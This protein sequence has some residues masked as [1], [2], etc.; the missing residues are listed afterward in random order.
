MSDMEDTKKP[1][2]VRSTKK[3]GGKK[4]KNPYIIFCNMK[5]EEVKAANPDLP[6]KEILSKLVEM[7][8]GLTEEQKASYRP[9]P[10]QVPQKKQVKKEEEIVEE[11]KE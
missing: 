5:R 7:W 6:S 8:N 11:K 9:K 2:I 10:R 1:K 3:K 4:N